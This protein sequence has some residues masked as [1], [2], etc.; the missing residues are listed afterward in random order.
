MSITLNADTSSGLV[1]TSDTSGEIKLQSAGADI[2]TVSSTGIAMA[3]GK[4]LPAASLTGTLPAIDGSAL[5]NLPSPSGKVFR[6]YKSGATQGIGTN[7]WTKITLETETF[8]TDNLFASS[9]FT[10]DVEGYYLFN[11]SVYFN[12][13]G[14]CVAALYKNGSQYSMGQD[15]INNYSA[16][17]SALVY[18]NGTTDYVELYGNSVSGYSVV[19]GATTTYLDGALV[20]TA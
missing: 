12:N 2:A 1:M 9:T 5:T 13:N 18:M 11:G 19:A 6:A 14:W 7:T 17:V 10:P 3:S 15:N 16:A 4:T 8:D 20:R